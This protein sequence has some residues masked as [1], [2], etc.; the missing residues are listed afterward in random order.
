MKVISL[1]NKSVIY[2]DY[3]DSCDEILN[4]K[5]PSWI[6][7]IVYKFLNYF[8]YVKVNENKLKLYC[9][10]EDKV[11][12]R[13]LNNLKKELLLINSGSIVLSDLLLQNTIIVTILQNLGYNILRGKW[14]YKFLCYDIV[15]KIAYVKNK[16]ISDLEITILSNENSDINV[17][18]IKLLAKECKILNIVTRNLDNFKYVEDDL[19]D[20]YGNIINVSTNTSKAC[21]YS[22]IILNFDFS[23]EEIKKCNFKKGIVLVQFTKEKFENRSGTTIVFYKL[24]MPVKYLKIF[25]EY[26]KYSQEIIYESLL[27]YKTSFKNLRKILKKDNISIKYFVGCNGK[28]PFNQ[29]KNNL[30]L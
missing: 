2:I 25:K 19:F 15:H 28:L 30:L 24:N 8:G 22:D 1:E 5:F 3:L 26:K 21:K 12:Q 10:S 18:N 16:K 23:I 7:K 17:E 4:D 27:Y 6:K 9:L 14:L 11:N 29:I 13:M 20:E